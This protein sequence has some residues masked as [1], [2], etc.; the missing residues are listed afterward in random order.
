MS[1]FR[2]VWLVAGLA[3]AGATL[4]L[5][6]DMF[7]KPEHF[8]AEPSSEVLVRLLNGTFSVSENSIARGRLVD[9]SVVSPEGRERVD[10][11]RWS[12]AGDT[13]T[14]RFRTGGA[15]TYVLGTSTR[16]NIIPLTGQEFNEYLASDG[17]PDALE[18]RRKAGELDRGVRERYAKHVKA[19]LQVGEARSEHF[20]SPLGYP[21]EIIPLENPYTLK[22]GATLELRLLLRGEAVSNQYVLY[23]GRTPAGGRIAQRNTRSD[24]EGLARIRL[25]GPGTWYVKFIHMRRLEGDSAD[26]ESTWATLTFAIK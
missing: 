5:A 6:H 19:L 1:R 22:A 14:F 23:G 16:P 18:A 3:V 4:A 24:V 12:M 15:G 13:S 8:Y 25:S 21:A 2:I 7:L 17:I 11:A 20:G 10:T 9:V 26:Y